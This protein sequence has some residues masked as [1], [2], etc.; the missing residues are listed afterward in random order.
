MR[1][2]QRELFV[3][4]EIL[5]DGMTI[6][7]GGYASC[8]ISDR[9]IEDV[10][11]CGIR[12]L[13]IISN[14]AAYPGRGVSRLLGEGRIRKMITTHIA[15]DASMHR[16]ARSRSDHYRSLRCPCYRERFSG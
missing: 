12:E 7:T 6:M 10:L 16:I 15:S 4:E 14:D 5:Q 9:L 8:G 13:T 11:K 3:L 1:S 2:K